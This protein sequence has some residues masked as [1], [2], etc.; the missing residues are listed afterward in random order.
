MKK[1]EKIIVFLAIIAVLYCCYHFFSASS[2]KTGLITS[3]TD[4]K[5]SKKFVKDV[6]SKLLN[7]EYHE[8]ELSIIEQADKDWAGNPFLEIKDAIKEIKKIKKTE[9]L[10]RKTNLAYSGFIT[11]G[12]RRLAIINGREYEE[13][14]ILAEETLSKKGYCL[15][16]ISN[17]RVVI[18]V[19]EGIDIILPLASTYR[20]SHN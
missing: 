3:K 13:G 19:K 7:D 8:K 16:E 1:R 20:S 2:L 5:G 11:T 10:N 4:I 15:K 18:G 6:I 9:P 12:N 14:E 17:Y